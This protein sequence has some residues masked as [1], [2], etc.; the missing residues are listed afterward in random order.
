MEKTDY[1]GAVG[2]MA[3][4]PRDHKWAHEGIW[5]PGYVT[6]IGAQWQDGKLEVVWPDG[7]PLWGDES[8]RKVRYK[9]TVDYKLPP[10]VLSYWKGKK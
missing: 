2:R 7:R 6:Y 1:A 9:G 5:G 3:F 4:H 10:A 8:W